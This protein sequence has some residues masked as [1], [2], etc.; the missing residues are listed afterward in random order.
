MS[1]AGFQLVYD[2]HQAGCRVWFFAPIGLALTIGSL[3]AWRSGRATGSV[4]PAFPILFFAMLTVVSFV[5]T[6][7]EYWHL[8]RARDHGE[9]QVLVGVV[10]AFE[11]APTYR[12]TERFRVADHEFSYSRFQTKQGF[13]RLSA[14]GGPMAQGLCVRLQYIDDH[15]L[16]LETAA[17]CPLAES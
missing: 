4:Q 13:H 16:R 11:P 14:D 9:A 3:I 12:G 1:S 10:S 6:W 17:H 15:I 2:I 7:G 5:V 8:L